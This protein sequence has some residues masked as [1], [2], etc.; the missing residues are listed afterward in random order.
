MYILA[1]P[2]APTQSP[3]AIRLHRSIYGVLDLLDV[4]SEFG[5]H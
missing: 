3:R 2:P 1:Q 5:V 4:W